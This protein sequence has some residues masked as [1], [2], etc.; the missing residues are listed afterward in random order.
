MN[1]QQTEQE[2]LNILADIDQIIHTPARLMIVT[3]LYVVESTDYVFLMRL[4]GLTWGNLFTHLTKLEDAGYITIEKTFKG[5]KPY[6]IVHLS[7]KG[8]IAFRKY[9]KNIKQVLDD[10]PD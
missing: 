7:D 4:T 6:T 8:R 2:K 10:L 1:N 5:K 3:Y 9:K